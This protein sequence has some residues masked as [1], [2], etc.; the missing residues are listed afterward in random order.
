MIAAYAGAS[1]RATRV[2]TRRMRLRSGGPGILIFGMA[3]PRCSMLKHSTTRCVL[4]LRKTTKTFRRNA[5][6]SLSAALRRA[7][8]VST[9]CTLLA[10]R[11]LPVRASLLRF[12]RLRI[13]FRGSTPE[14]HLRRDARHGVHRLL[15]YCADCLCSRSIAISDD[16]S[17][18]DVRMC[19]IEGR[20]VCQALRQTRRRCAAGFQLE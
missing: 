18:D 17:R 11:C 16:G 6:P 2:S 1:I 8:T 10:R 9:V 3:A 4:T 15:V 14:N 5:G 20:F 19:D 12:G 13:T 7:V